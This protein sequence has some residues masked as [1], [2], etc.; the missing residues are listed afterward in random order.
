MI[1]KTI[2]KGL[3][4]FTKFILLQNNV[5]LS[6]SLDDCTIIDFYSNQIV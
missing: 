4:L 1:N 3:C 5:F 2:K 6:V